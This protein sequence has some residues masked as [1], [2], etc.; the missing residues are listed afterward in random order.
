[1]RKVL[2]FL[3]LAALVAFSAGVSV[4]AFSSFAIY[5]H[6]SLCLCGVHFRAD[7]RVRPL[8]PI[9]VPLFSWIILS[10]AYRL[11]EHRLFPVTCAVRI[12]VRPTDILKYF[13]FFFQDFR[14]CR[15][16]LPLGCLQEAAR[17]GDNFQL[18]CRITIAWLPILLS[19]VTHNLR[20]EGSDEKRKS[21]RKD[22]VYCHTLLGAMRQIWWQHSLLRR[23]FFVRFFV[24]VDLHWEV[25][26]PRWE[27]ANQI[28]STGTK[29]STKKEASAEERHGNKKNCQSSTSMCPCRPPCTL[30]P[31][32]SA[33]CEK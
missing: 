9:F 13:I 3:C 4:R 32:L 14:R 21:S 24:P 10:A 5:T 12:I 17:E 22:E 25:N 18:S 8:R 33:P 30:A 31:R 29:K 28:K 26:G 15:I 6:E 7:A 1:M 16:Q 23:G 27:G 19:N 2:S 20:I 11:V